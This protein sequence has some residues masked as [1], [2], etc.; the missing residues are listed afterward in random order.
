MFYKIVTVNNVGKLTECPLYFDEIPEND[1]WDI[2]NLNVGATTLMIHLVIGQMKERGKGAIVNLCSGTD[3]M[4]LPLMSLYASTKTL[5]RY[6]SDAI[7]VEYSKH[8]L[9]IQ[10]LSPFYVNTKLV[11]YNKAIKVCKNKFLL[12]ISRVKMKNWIFVF[13]I[14]RNIV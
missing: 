10:T 6:F 1:I 4:P 11:G 3:G 13:F 5:V 14:G 8:G 9:V 7:R 12:K 2:I